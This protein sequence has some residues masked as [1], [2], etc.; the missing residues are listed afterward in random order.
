[1][2]V[3]LIVEG[4]GEEEAAP[5][6]VRRIADWA[7]C[8]T[9]LTIPRPLR[10]RRNRIV[11]KEELERAIE[12]VARKVGPGGPILVLL[13][14]DDD[15]AAT[16][17]PLLLAR[18]KAARSDRAIAVVLAVLEYEA[19]F[20]AAAASLRGKRTLPDDLATPSNPEA[21]RDAKGWLDARMQRGYS[22]TLEQPKLTAVVD[23]DDARSAPSFDKLVRDVC[24][25]LGCEPP[26][27]RT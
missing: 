2:N 26:A 10:V 17:G 23:L 3:G 22:E 20:L 24:A 25:L 1:M 19:W 13:D 14:A 8:N 4:N 7:G 9:P 16:L 5:L 15:C 12:L 11:K 21:I 18:A 27:R 6:L